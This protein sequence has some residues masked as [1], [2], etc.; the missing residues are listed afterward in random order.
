MNHCR[1]TRM[2]LV[3]RQGKLSIDSEGLPDIY[4]I[5]QLLTRVSGQVHLSDDIIELRRM[6]LKGS[7]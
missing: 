6:S 7:G 3:V 5:G 4:T 2:G 1:I